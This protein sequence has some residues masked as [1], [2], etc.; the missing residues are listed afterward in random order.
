[1]YGF[2]TEGT[3]NYNSRGSTLFDRTC[4]I[5]YENRPAVCPASLD[6]NGVGR[7]V[8][9][10]LRGGLRISLM[11]ML[12]AAASLSGMKPISYSSLLRVIV[13]IV[14]RFR[15]VNPEFQVILLW[16]MPPGT[17]LRRPVSA[18][19]V[20]SFSPAGGEYFPQCCPPSQAC[21]P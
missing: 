21:T 2:G 6:G 11:R 19:P 1:M 9:R 5:R 15:K 13:I 17:P 18:P 4:S 14:S 10:S 3:R 7:T 8:L 12:P 20:P 16:K